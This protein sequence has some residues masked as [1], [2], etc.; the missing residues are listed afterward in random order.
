[1]GRGEFDV[2]EAKNAPEQ[3]GKASGVIPVL[4]S[5]GTETHDEAVV[6]VDRDATWR[7]PFSAEGLR[8]AS[9]E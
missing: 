9:G 7:S 4:F 1:M 8:P 3:A 6:A 5:A 2:A